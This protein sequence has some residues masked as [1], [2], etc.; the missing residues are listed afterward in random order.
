MILHSDLRKTFE[1]HD[2]CDCCDYGPIETIECSLRMGALRAELC[3][4]CYSTFIS[5]V[6]EYPDQHRHD[7][8]ILR[9]LAWVGNE[10]L[11]RLPKKSVDAAL[12]AAIDKPSTL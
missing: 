7:D 10:I 12:A 2:R 1:V 5:G 11:S 3:K 8:T 9:S 4:I 6:L